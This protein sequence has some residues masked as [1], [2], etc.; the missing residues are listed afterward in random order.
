[1][2]LLPAMKKETNYVIWF[3]I[4]LYNFINRLFFIDIK[5]GMPSTKNGPKIYLLIG[6]N[7]IS[8]VFRFDDGHSPGQ[9]NVC[10]WYFKEP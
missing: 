6:L 10:Q 1:M 3:Y 7:P 8:V 9:K 4:I 5:Q 2:P